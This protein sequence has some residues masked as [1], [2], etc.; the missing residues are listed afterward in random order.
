MISKLSTARLGNK[1][2]RSNRLNV[3]S[4]PSW[5]RAHHHLSGANRGNVGEEGMSRPSREVYR[6]G[7]S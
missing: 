3:A 4:K 5:T 2:S 1:R 6:E 7:W